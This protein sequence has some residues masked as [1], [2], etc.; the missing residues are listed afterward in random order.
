M[1]YK[2]TRGGSENVSFGQVVQELGRKFEHNREIVIFFLMKYWEKYSY[3][4]VIDL[5]LQSGMSVGF[6][7]LLNHKRGCL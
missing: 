1:K 3:P 7:S 4:A 2:S 5:L 6:R